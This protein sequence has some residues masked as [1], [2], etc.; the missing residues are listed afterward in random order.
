MS[1]LGKK[2]TTLYFMAAIIV[3]AGVGGYFLGNFFPMQAAST[4]NQV[5]LKIGGSSTVTPLVNASLTKLHEF[6][7]N[8][9]VTLEMTDSGTGVTKTKDGS[10]DIGMSSKTWGANGASDNI[11]CWKIARDGICLIVNI[12]SVTALNLTKAEVNGIYNGSITDWSTLNGNNGHSGLPA[13]A[14]TAIQRE[15][16]SGTR[17]YFE[18][19]VNGSAAGQYHPGILGGT[20]IT[21]TENPL[22]QSAVISTQYSIGYVGIAYTTGATLCNVTTY[23]GLTGVDTNSFITPTIASVN[24]PANTYPI[25][26]N[27]WLMTTSH[28]AAGTAANLYLE[29]MMSSYGAAAVLVGGGV[30]LSPLPSSVT[31]EDHWGQGLI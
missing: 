17:D 5:I 31:A 8:I 6:Y 9:I 15:A 14:I 11:Y 10:Y 24:A 22:V 7:P 3:V 20:I 16:G 28:P 2:N 26:R 18:S 13:H 27:L 23:N 4:R 29:F 1:S 30:P 12:P 21:A 25:S 19:W